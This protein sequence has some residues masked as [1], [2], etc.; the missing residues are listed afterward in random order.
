VVPPRYRRRQR[1][2]AAGAAAAEREMRGSE[3]P[4]LHGSTAIGDR[5]RLPDHRTGRRGDRR[6]GGSDRHNP[7]METRR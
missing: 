1:R 7:V 5:G 4:A 2:L 3:R 6:S